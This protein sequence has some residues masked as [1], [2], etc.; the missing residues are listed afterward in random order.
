MPASVNPI[1]ALTP[2]IGFVTLTAANTATDGTGTVGTLY[3]AGGNGGR[4]D[5]VRFIPLG[6]NIATKA[7]LFLNNGASQAVAANNSLILDLPLPGTT[8]SNT[9]LIGTPFLSVFN[10]AL[11]AGHIINAT[12]ATAVATGWKITA[13]AGDF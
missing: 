7:Y 12:L 13:Y 1:F 5:R 11:K 8:A 4:V 6:T 3:T 9:A 2:K 10:R